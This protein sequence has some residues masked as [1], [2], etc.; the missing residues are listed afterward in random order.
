[1]K[2]FKIIITLALLG[3]LFY[4]AFTTDYKGKTVVEHIK[5]YWHG[6]PVE[7]TVV[8]AGKDIKN[9]LDKRVEAVKPK[10]SDLAQKGE[11]IEEYT[12]E[13]QKVINDAIEK[14]LH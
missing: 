4:L 7:K 14:H 8:K 6:S 13:E 2:A 1:M 3:G 11:Q 5:D 12:E 9:D 10:K